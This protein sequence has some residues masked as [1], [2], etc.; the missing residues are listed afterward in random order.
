MVKGEGIVAVANKPLRR[1]RR[2]AQRGKMPVPE[3]EITT[4]EILEPEEV[5]EEISDDPEDTEQV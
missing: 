2:T 4:T 5:I 1:R 3:G